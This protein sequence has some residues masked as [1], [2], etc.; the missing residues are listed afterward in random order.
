M[1]M[2][3]HATG[4]VGGKW[5]CKCGFEGWGRLL[6]WWASKKKRKMSM[7][8]E[9]ACWWNMCQG[10]SETSCSLSKVELLLSFKCIVKGMLEHVFFCHF[11]YN[12]L[13]RLCLFVYMYVCVCLCVCVLS[14]LLITETKQSTFIHYDPIYI[15]LY[16]SWGRVVDG[17]ADL[18]KG[19]GSARWPPGWE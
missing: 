16:G 9:R 6:G 3:N 8:Y 10:F 14:I 2:L 18:E 1:V 12:F 13:F 4:V 11:L 19:E 15:S 5:I 7:L 17:I